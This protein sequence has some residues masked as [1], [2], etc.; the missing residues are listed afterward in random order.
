MTQPVPGQPADLSGMHFGAASTAAGPGPEPG[1]EDRD[2]PGSA[3]PHRAAPGMGARPAVGTPTIVAAAIMITLGIMALLIGS[4]GSP[5]PITAS[6]ADQQA[7]LI[8]QERIAAATGDDESLPTPDEAA[9]GLV[10]ARGAAGSVARL[11]NTGTTSRDLLPYFDTTVP[12]RLVD[13]WYTP[14][15]T[16]GP[17]VWTASRPMGVNTDGTIPVTWTLTRGGT[18]LAWADADYDITRQVFTGLGVHTTLAGART[19]TGA[20]R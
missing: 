13:A 10:L 5:A 12:R 11:Q 7:T 8:L 14:G 1:S 18:L 6:D 16:A 4:T 17:A 19:G 9:R 20:T 2:G 15:R 3:E